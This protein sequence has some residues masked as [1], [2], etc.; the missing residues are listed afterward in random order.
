MHFVHLSVNAWSNDS[1]FTGGLIDPASPA[2]AQPVRSPEDPDWVR[3]EDGHPLAPAERRYLQLSQQEL[4]K[5]A[6]LELVTTGPDAEEVAVD[7]AATW[8]E[9]LLLSPMRDLITNSG[10]LGLTAITI[11][12]VGV[13][14]GLLLKFVVSLFQPL[15]S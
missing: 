6:T 15:G 3:P 13:L 11:L 2:P 8:L 9:R 1:D 7:H 10:W 5:Y 12:T 14:G 4:E